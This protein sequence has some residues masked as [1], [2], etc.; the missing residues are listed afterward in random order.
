MHAQSSLPSFHDLVDLLAGQIL[1][2]DL[3]V[4]WGGMIVLV[5]MLRRSR[6]GLRGLGNCGDGK[7]GGGEQSGCGSGKGQGRWLQTGTAPGGLGSL[8]LLT[9]FY[10]RRMHLPV[11]VLGPET[12]GFPG[13][14]KRSGQS[15]AS[16]MP[17]RAVTSTS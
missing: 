1:G 12:Q 3:E 11:K 5:L 9:E 16:R 7:N 10:A 15:R 17:M 14:A 8:F 13:K 2:Q 4:G 6:R